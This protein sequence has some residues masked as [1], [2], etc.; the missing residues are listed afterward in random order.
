MVFVLLTAWLLV[1]CDSGKDDGDDYDTALLVKTGTLT[2]LLGDADK[3]DAFVVELPKVA[4]TIHEA[5]LA[6]FKNLRGLF[7]PRRFP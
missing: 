6:G 7:C 1:A 3:G 5:G 4:A 2:G